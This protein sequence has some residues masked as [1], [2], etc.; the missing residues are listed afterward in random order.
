MDDLGLLAT[1][2]EV[3]QALTAYLGEP[4]WRW[5]PSDDEWSCLEVVVHL[6]DIER[7]LYGSWVQR[8]LR[9]ERPTFGGRF[10]AARRAREQGFNEQDPAGVLREFAAE[11]GRTVGELR[12][13]PAAAWDRPWVDRDGRE[14]PA[15]ALLHRFANHDAIHLGQIARVKRA[16]L[17][18]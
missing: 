5:K 14:W 4:A 8:V 7:E 10:E 12:R 3:V 16:Q 2:P 1:T 17:A 6:L 18:Y 11:R 9:E 13:A 15:R